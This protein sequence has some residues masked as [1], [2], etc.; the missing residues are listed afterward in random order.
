[1]NSRDNPFKPGYGLPPP[2]LA[3]REEPQKLLAGKLA[4][5]A[6]GGLVNGV[7][8]Y[9]PRGM[10]KTVLLGWLQEQCKAKGIRHVSG[11]SATMLGSVSTLAKALLSSSRWLKQWRV[12]LGIK[13]LGADVGAGVSPADTS[14]GE[15]WYLAQR[16]IKRC[17]KKPMVVLLDEAHEPPDFEVLRVLLHVVQQVAR[18]AP[19]LL[20][21][22]GTPLL[23]EILT[24]VKATFIER[25][26]RVGLGYLDEQS[27]AAA[28]SVPL[29]KDGMT[30]AGNAL[31]K[32]VG[33]SQ[34]YPFF[35]QRWGAALWEHSKKAGVAKL[36]LDD[37][38]LVEDS[39]DAKKTEF[40][41]SRYETISSF[42]ELLAAARAVAEELIKNDGIDHASAL[43]I[44]EGGLGTATANG[45]SREAKARKI[46]H[47]LS[48]IDLFWRP[49]GSRRIVPGIPSFMNYIQARSSE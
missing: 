22:A 1:M 10:G 48:R 2:Y 5:M 47:E 29:E 34:A 25:A 9:G 14:T 33:N 16:L 40:Y 38:N 8:I 15:E 18:E 36:T 20:V 4:T 37:V 32:A 44:V 49:P 39:V 41:E 45:A 42:H 7:V 12:G 11:T 27:A 17:R 23:T 35:L 28:I 3:G 21:L 31:D 30:I 6:A 26:D 43:S 19:F 24:K 13:G 46:M